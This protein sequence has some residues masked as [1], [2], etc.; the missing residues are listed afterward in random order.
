LS[1]VASATAI[2]PIMQ[3]AKAEQAI[4]PKRIIPL[5][6]SPGECAPG[7][8]AASGPKVADWVAP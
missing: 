2:G 6:Q 1:A 4:H 5:P 3:A 8:E 7:S